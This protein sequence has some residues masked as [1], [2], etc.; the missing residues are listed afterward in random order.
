MIIFIYGE[1]SFRCRQKLN[2]L[3]TKFLNEVDATGNSLVELSGEKAEFSELAEAINSTSLLSKKRM[4]IIDNLFSNKGDIV[5]KQVLDF[6][7]S[8]K[9]DK[10]SN[11]VIFKDSIVKTKNVKNKIQYLKM[12]SGSRERAVPQKQLLLFK[13][14]LDQAHVQQFSLLSNTEI[15]TWIKKEVEKRGGQISLRASQMLAGFI[16]SDLWQ[17]NQEI[18][19]LINYKSA[20][21]LQLGK[22]E[23]VPIEIEDVEKMVKGSFDEN[24]FALTDAI[25]NNNKALAGRLLEEQ[26][27][28]GLADTYLLNM[29]IRQFKILLR[30]KQAIE[31]GQ[32]SRQMATSLNLH[33]F[34]IQKGIGQARNF[35]LIFLKKIL[36]QLV[37]IDFE[38]KTGRLDTLA[39]LNLLL[40]KI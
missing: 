18:D 40:A 30:I 12:D 23:V 28:A 35:S 14:L 1:D 32:T 24:I 2:E 16:G 36:D 5:F 7:E 37:K 39:G 10:D 4:I 27:S 9:D 29:F 6:L 11:I 34:I 17:A 19:K 15:N 13:Y 25:S 3:K 26:L 8:R 22:K 20:N 21:Q 33:P 31:N 38:M